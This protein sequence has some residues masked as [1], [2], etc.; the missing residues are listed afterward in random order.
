MNAPFRPDQ[1]AAEA[2]QEEETLLWAGRPS[3]RRVVLISMALLTLGAPITLLALLWILITLLAF[4]AGSAGWLISLTIGLLLLLPG[5]CMAA[6]SFFLLRRMSQMV[7][8][9][10]DER[11]LF[12]RVGRRR[13]VHSYPLSDLTELASGLLAEGAGSGHLTAAF[14]VKALR[15]ALLG[16]NAL[17]RLRLA[18][19]IGFVD[20][21]EARRAFGLLRSLIGSGTL[22]DE[23]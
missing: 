15:R 3:R 13:S 11:A 17:R 9:L 6:G 22:S 21:P 10:T 1:I 7:Y 8:A 4:S 18:W 20:I 23:V 12:I 5:A 14:W 2:I 19:H 16:R